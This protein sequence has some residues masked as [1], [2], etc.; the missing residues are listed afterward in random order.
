MAERMIVAASFFASGGKEQQEMSLPKPVNEKFSYSDYVTWPDDERW[1]IIDGVAYNMTPAPVVKHQR[2]VSKLDRKLGEQA[3]EKGCT[4]FI[5]PTDVVFDEHNVVQPDVLVVCD[6]AKITEKNIRG[7][8]DLV[9][10]VLSPST[11]VKDRREKKLLYERFGV[12]EYILIHPED[13]LV[14][15]FFLEGGA[16]RAPDIFNWDE[17][18]EILSLAIDLPLWEVFEKNREQGEKGP[19][20][21]NAAISEDH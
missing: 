16:Y 8:P 18:L 7:A 17:P 20:E 6:R 4:L 12:R 3:E 11:S 21:Q 2:I 5:A 13:E 14:E 9:I 19:E 15:R 10:E 1:E